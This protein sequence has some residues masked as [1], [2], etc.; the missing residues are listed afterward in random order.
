[1]DGGNKKKC[2][3][4]IKNNPNTD[5]INPPDAAPV[6]QSLSRFTEP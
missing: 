4:S 5:A 3:V 6:F 2:I 1:M